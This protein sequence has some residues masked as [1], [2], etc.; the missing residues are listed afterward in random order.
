MTSVQFQQSRAEPKNRLQKALTW[1]FRFSRVLGIFGCIVMVLLVILTVADVVMRYF[2]NSPW[3][4][5]YEITELMMGTIVFALIAFCVVEDAH[6][7]VDIV[8]TKIPAK[9]R[10]IV[11]GILYFVAF[12]L[13]TVLAWQSVNRGWLV[14]EAGNW[15]PI[16]HTPE[17]PF[18]MFAGFGFFIMALVL[19]SKSIFAFLEFVHNE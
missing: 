2:F 7:K 18:F 17:G 11:S 3:A 1:T 4:P 8:T 12:G 9:P 13:F 14:L 5:T 15:T 10:A 6:I 19:L 16:T